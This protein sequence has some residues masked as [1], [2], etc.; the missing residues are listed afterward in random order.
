M[1]SQFEH[2]A[3]NFDLDARSSLDDGERSLKVGG[4]SF[5]NF[6]AD[7]ATESVQGDWRDVTGILRD[8]IFDNE[9]ADSALSLDGISQNVLESDFGNCHA[10]K[11]HVDRDARVPNH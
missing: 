10:E 8:Q 3:T 6:E 7:R 9:S 4:S 5:E 1:S 2:P 11:G